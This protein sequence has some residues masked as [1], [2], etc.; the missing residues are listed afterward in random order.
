[1]KLLIELVPSTAWE[2]NLRNRVEADE[3]DQ[4]KSWC[5]RKAGYRCQICG[6][7]GPKH[8]VECHEIWD[9]K[10]GIQK[11]TGLIA[12]C[13]ACHE[14][15]HFGRAQIVGREKAAI[16]HLMKVNDWTKQEALDHIE[17]AFEVWEIRSQRDWTLDLSWVET[18]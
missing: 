16:K 17:E 9:Y 1:M 12:L 18:I 8:P 10:D 2:D 5:Y 4:L 13:P 15:K 6:G 11:L 14:V 7:K 3:W